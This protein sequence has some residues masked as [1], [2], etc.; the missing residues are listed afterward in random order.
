MNSTKG[1]TAAVRK[2]FGGRAVESVEKCSRERFRVGTKSRP[3]IV[4][5]TRSSFVGYPIRCNFRARDE[6]LNG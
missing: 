6:R 4:P 5:F 2:P 3:V 1:V